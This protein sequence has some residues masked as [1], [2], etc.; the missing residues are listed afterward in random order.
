VSTALN[1]TELKVLTDE[2]NETPYKVPK[3]THF[4]QKL[5]HFISKY[6][7]KKK[8][9]K[10]KENLLIKGKCTSLILLLITNFNFFKKI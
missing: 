6:F 5:I 2:K 9:K 10:K 8:K 3:D 7:A 4:L 1:F